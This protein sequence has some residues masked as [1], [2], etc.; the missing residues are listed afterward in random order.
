MKKG[1]QTARVIFPQVQSKPDSHVE[2]VAV[3][4]PESHVEREVFISKK[5]FDA[6]RN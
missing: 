6:F 2:E 3:S 5:D 4:K 1:N